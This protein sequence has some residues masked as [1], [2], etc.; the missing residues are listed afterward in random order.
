MFS[1]PG[2]MLISLPESCLLTTSTVL[3]SY[4]GPFIK[5]YAPKNHF[6]YQEMPFSKITQYNS[7]FQCLLKVLSQPFNTILCILI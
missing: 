7:Y 1:Q 4:L 6:K 3:N 5:R 2:H